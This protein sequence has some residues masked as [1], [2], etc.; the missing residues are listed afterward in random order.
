MKEMDSYSENVR[1]LG[2]GWQANTPLCHSSIVP[3][4]QCP[5]SP[6]RFSVTICYS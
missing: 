1:H 4:P 3:D 5:Y 2:S 6:S